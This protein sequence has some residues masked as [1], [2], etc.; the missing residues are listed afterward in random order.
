MINVKRMAIFLTISCILLFSQPFLVQGGLF[1]S[2]RK[3]RE[4]ELKQKIE[5]ERQIL[6][7]EYVKILQFLVKEYKELEEQE[8]K[9]EKIEKSKEGSNENSSNASSVKGSE[10]KKADYVAKKGESLNLALNRCQVFLTEQF[11]DSEKKEFVKRKLLIPLDKDY[12][13]E[14]CGV[15]VSLAKKQ[16][17]EF[18]ITEKNEGEKIF[19]ILSDYYGMTYRVGSLTEKV[20]KKIGDLL[21]DEEAKAVV[22]PEGIVEVWDCKAGHA[23]VESFLRELI[24]NEYYFYSYDLVVR[25]GK[26][27]YRYSGDI[28]PLVE[29]SL[30]TDGSIVGGEVLHDPTGKKVLVKVRFVKHGVYVD[31][32]LMINEGETEKVVWDGEVCLE[33]KLYDKKQDFLKNLKLSEPKFVSDTSKSSDLKGGKKDGS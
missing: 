8:K 26:K 27:D 25:I 30:G 15:I 14:E 21:V 18:L 13:K 7:K 4:E 23:K 31:K 9:L 2:F 22:Y 17:E 16:V 24:E 12:I 19:W 5:M 32:V 28:L 3:G 20:K 10:E 6:E 33:L 1:D 29:S 11:K